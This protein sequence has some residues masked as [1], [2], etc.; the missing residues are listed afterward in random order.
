MSVGRIPILL[1]ALASAGTAHS[2][3]IDPRAYIEKA[4]AL[5]ANGDHAL[6]RAYLD[7]S[8]I[9][10]RLAPGERSRAYYLRGYSFY[11]RGHFVSAA[12]DYAHALEFN[13]DNPAALFAMGGLYQH[14]LGRETDLQLA[15]QFF[16]KAAELDHP[17]AQLYVGNA[18]LVGEGTA[19]NLDEARRWLGMA[20][21]AGFGPA[22]TR[23]AS[24]F[25][26]PHTDAP[27]PAQA[28]F[29]YE[30]A[31]Q[32]GSTDALLALG[33]M[34]LNGELGDAPSGTTLDLFRKAAEQGSG[35]AMAIL[36]HAYMTG[37]D[38]QPDFALARDWY[39]KATEF[40]APGSYAGIGH[41]HEAGL[42]VPVDIGMAESWYAKGGEA[43]HTDALLRLLYL[44]A[45]S[46]REAGAAQWAQRATVTG[47]ARALNGYAWLLA[48]SPIPEIRNGE[49]A[50][51]HAQQA[52][53]LDRKAAYLD[54]LAAAYAEM[55]RFE[56]AVAVQRQALD[57]ADDD[58]ALIEELTAHLSAY[59]Q[60]R[61]WRE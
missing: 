61:P 21:E 13:P 28:R 35:P 19:A 48:T 9:S 37:S 33:Y 39:L 27:D 22:M 47:N 5:I 1:I 40:A 7:P 23:L 54:T 42:G 57:A 26:E 3:P 17:G 18:Y 30:Q 16:H 53:T 11:A 38:V 6:A 14:G 52:V 2:G 56:D 43:G 55:S 58:P 41:I 50:L 24:S 60:A 8:V 20:A 59:E 36:G 45:G 4:V 15:F 51:R 31:A 46:G 44:L 10:H 12:A 34:F 29:W 49:Q 25:R 32:A